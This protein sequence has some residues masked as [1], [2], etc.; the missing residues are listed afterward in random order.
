MIRIA[1]WLVVLYYALLALTSCRGAVL[2]WDPNP[3]S[4]LAGYRVYFGETS[5]G[6]TEVVDVG[7]TVMHFVPNEKPGFLAVTAYDTD[8]LES[9]FSEEVFW[10]GRWPRPAMLWRLPA[11]PVRVEWSVD[12]VVWFPLEEVPASAPRIYPVQ[13]D[14][15]EPYKF[16]RYTPL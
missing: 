12:L 11:Y 15:A 8:G 9:D 6:Y 3:E 16:F 2:E 1:L 4:N 5:R 10:Q 14:R 7:N 13:I